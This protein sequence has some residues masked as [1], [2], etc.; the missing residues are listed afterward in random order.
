MPS[1]NAIRVKGLRELNRAFARADRDIR[2]GFRGALKDAAEPV[3]ADAESL[4]RERIANI[5][6]RWSRMRVGITTRV[7]YVAPREKGVTTRGG[8]AARRPNL[9]GLL[10]DRA[11]QPALDQNREQVVRSVERLLGDLGRDWAHG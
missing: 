7:V 5:G 2:L 4:S 3:R 9:A 10:M 11:M 1:T 6:D 8:A